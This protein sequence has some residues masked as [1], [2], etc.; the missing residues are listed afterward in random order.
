M[1][2][3][4]SITKQRYIKSG[5]KNVDSS[6]DQLVSNQTISN[7]NVDA[8][9]SILH[10]KFRVKI[11]ELQWTQRD[12]NDG[13]NTVQTTRN[14]LND[15]QNIFTRLAGSSNIQTEEALNYIE[16]IR[17]NL[18]TLHNHL[19]R[20][21]SNISVMIENLN[22]ANSRVLKIAKNDSEQMPCL[23]PPFCEHPHVS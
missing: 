18:D 23:L 20:T 11:C 2:N 8:P 21:I 1:T 6:L 5:Q 22:A 13:I 10:E 15:L 3:V 17:S 9:N 4:I 12:A 14:G 19:N 7:S 16:N